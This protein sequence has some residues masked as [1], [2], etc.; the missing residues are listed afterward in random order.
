[1]TPPKAAL[2]ALAGIVA[3]AAVF[4]AG[5]QVDPITP[6]GDTINLPASGVEG[7]NPEATL[8]FCR[9]GSTKVT[10]HIVPGVGQSYEL[11]RLKDN[12]TELLTV[13]VANGEPSPAKHYYQTVVGEQNEPAA[14]DQDGVKCLEDKGA[15]KQ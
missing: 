10:F 12:V 15:L 3:T 2:G 4:L 5:D 8:A 14:F 11:L 9:D 13:T 1:M 7:L 6:T